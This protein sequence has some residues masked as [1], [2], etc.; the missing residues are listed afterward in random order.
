MLTSC[1]ASLSVIMMTSRRHNYLSGSAG[2]RPT[3]V[4]LPH[5]VVISYVENG[6]SKHIMC[7]HFSNLWGKKVQW[8][9]RH[10]TTDCFVVE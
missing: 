10:S 9:Q 2:D 1:S 6:V 7:L 5:G 4:F 3:T 8:C